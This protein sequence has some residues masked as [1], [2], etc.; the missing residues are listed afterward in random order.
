VKLYSLTLN[1]IAFYTPL[2]GTVSLK[3]P[4][5]LYTLG[6]LSAIKILYY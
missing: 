6:L 5:P 3:P 1:L 2:N 4:A